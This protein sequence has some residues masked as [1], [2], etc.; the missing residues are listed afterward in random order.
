MKWWNELK[1]TKR[2]KKKCFC[3]CHWHYK[4]FVFFLLFS[5]RMLCP[6]A[7]FRFELVE[8]KVFQNIFWPMRRG[9]TVKIVFKIQ[10]I[11]IKR[12][13]LTINAILCIQTDR[14]QK[15]LF[16]AVLRSP[17]FPCAKWLFHSTLISI[18]IQTIWQLIKSNAKKI[19]IENEFKCRTQKICP[20]VWYEIYYELNRTRMFEPA[21]HSIGT[22]CLWFTTQGV[23]KYEHQNNMCSRTKENMNSVNMS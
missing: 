2:K 10:N 3:K 14:F 16:V 9:C 22:C 18:E 15:Y 17:I 12:L 7:R 23:R 5:S 20:F 13:L 8:R 1:H 4:L 11:P 19:L 6:F 21:R